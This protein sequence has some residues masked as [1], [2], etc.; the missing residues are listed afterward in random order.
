MKK[1]FS[2]LLLLITVFKISIAQTDL[3]TS[4]KKTSVMIPM[5]D[6]IKLYTTILTPVNPPQKVPILIIRT[7]YGASFPIP[8]D[9]VITM[10]PSNFNYYYMAREGY[11]FAFQD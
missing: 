8:D 9:T 4:Y 11:I 1:Y 7:P 2:C 5:R 3:I 6:G 10:T